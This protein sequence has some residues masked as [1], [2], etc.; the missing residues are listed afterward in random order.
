MLPNTR[1]RFAAAMLLALSL[2]PA[3]SLAQ[4]ATAAP[5]TGESRIGVIASI[6]CGLFVRASFLIP[7]PFVIAGAVATCAFAF[8]DGLG[9]PDTPASGTR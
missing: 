6:G 5:E 2:V 8:L 3:A 4:D 9:D 1:R 7:H